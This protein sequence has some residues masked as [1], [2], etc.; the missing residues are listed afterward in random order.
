MGSCS[1]SG[2]SFLKELGYNVV[3]VPREGIEP[4]LLI[5]RQGGTVAQLGTLD[6]LTK[7]APDQALPK[8]TRD[9]AATDLSG[10]R[11]DRLKAGIGLN[12]L[13]SL[14]GA[15]GGKLGVNAAFSSAKS[16]QFRF[17][18]VL[19]DT[20]QPFD[21]GNYLR[22]ADIDQGNPVLDQ[23]LMGNGR[24]YVITETIKSDKLSVNV[25]TKSEHGGG[26]ELPVIQQAVGGDVS[27]ET[28][29]E[30]KSNLTFK[31]KAHLTFGFKAFE[32]GVANGEITLMAVKAS[33]AL[34]MR[35]AT[36]PAPRPDMVVA[37]DELVS[38]AD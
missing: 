15:L 20:V 10:Q 34:A 13:G 16:L 22:D 5:G 32:I 6:K 12:I 27:V 1:D 26:L 23:Y 7:H 2:V 35:G 31:G 30:G 24:L 3:R 25:E 28:G 36:K 18:D 11:T 9:L 29:K 4:L 21:I 8:I 37:Q 14:I 19:T 38:F 33:A 17:D